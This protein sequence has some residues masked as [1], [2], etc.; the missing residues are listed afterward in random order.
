M[1]SSSSIW[2]SPSHEAPWA[3]T[4]QNGNPLR[5]KTRAQRV[6]SCLNRGFHLG[7]HFARGFAA[8]LADQQEKITRIWALYRRAV[9]F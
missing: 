8:L 4:L 6:L 2:P 1:I 3:K 9:A 7:L 5:L